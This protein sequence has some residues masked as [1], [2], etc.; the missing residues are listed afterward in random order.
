[1]FWFF[2]FVFFFFLSSDFVLVGNH[3]AIWA[4]LWPFLLYLFFQIGSPILAWVA[5]RLKSSYLLH[6]GI[7]SMLY[8]AQLVFWDRVLLTFSCTGCPW[9]KIPPVSVS[10]AAGIIGLTH[11]A[12]IRVLYFKNNL[13]WFPDIIKVTNIKKQRNLFY[14]SFVKV[15]VVEYPKHPEV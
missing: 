6:S 7:T 9:T 13:H 10:W 4:S 2:V 5:F 12:H 14:F 8:H 15:F 1:V 3:S 11:H